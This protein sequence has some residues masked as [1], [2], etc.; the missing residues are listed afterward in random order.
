[1]DERIRISIPADDEGYVSFQC[2]NCRERF[3]LHA[4]EFDEEDWSTLYC[5]LCGLSNEPGTFLT[6][7]VHR[8]AQAHAENLLQDLVD[9]MLKGFERSTRGSKFIKFKRG[10]KPPK[11]PIP[12]LRE[13]TDLAIVQYPCCGYTAK[14]AH[15]DAL[16]GTYC[17]YCGT[18][19]V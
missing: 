13:V 11:V 8:V 5:P 9:D 10:P 7:D 1:M 19:H 17:P 18:E 14:V 4:A 6:P 15:S 2:P 12:E 16:S 3:K